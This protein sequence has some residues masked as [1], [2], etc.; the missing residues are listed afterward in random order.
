[1]TARVLVI[2]ASRLRSLRLPAL[3][4]TVVV[5][6]VARLASL[7]VASLVAEGLLKSNPAGRLV[8]PTLYVPSASPLK[9]YSPF[10]LVTVVAIAVPLPLNKVTSKP[11]IPS[12]PVC[13]P[14]LLASY[15]TRLPRELVPAG[16]TSPRSTDILSSPSVRLNTAVLDAPAGAPP[17]PMAPPSLSRVSSEPAF[18]VATV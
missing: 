4:V 15:Q 13:K 1:M 5:R 18:C 7:P 2:P 11:D 16:G 6:P 17:V 3:S 9:R 8:K 14:S 10:S 12:S